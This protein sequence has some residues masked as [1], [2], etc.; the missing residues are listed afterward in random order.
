MPLYQLVC[1]RSVMF[2]LTIQDSSARDGCSG[3]YSGSLYTELAEPG[4]GGVSQWAISEDYFV[5]VA[6]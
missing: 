6:I 3:V 2:P 4:G 1:R 5:S